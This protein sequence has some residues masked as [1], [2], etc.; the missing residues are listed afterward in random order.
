MM[1]WLGLLVVLIPCLTM[2]SE[3]AEQAWQ[4]ID[5]GAVVIDVRTPQEFAAGHLTQAM[6]IPISQLAQADLSFIDAS[7]NVVV[8]CRSG[9]RSAKAQ[10]LLLTEG[11]IHVHNGGGLQELRQKRSE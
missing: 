3:R 6:N 7:D 2:A 8:Y 5:S 10:K 1:K 9:N 4:W 11:Y